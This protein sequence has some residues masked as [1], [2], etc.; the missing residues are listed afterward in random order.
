M[1]AFPSSEH[2]AECST[3]NSIQLPGST[4]PKYPSRIL[5]QHQAS[6]KD[7]VGPRQFEGHQIDHHCFSQN[8]SNETCN[9][10]EFAKS[11]FPYQAELLCYVISYLGK[12]ITSLQSEYLKKD[13][14]IK[15]N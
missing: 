9:Y 7:W 1:D 5:K 10:L 8:T 3:G 6:W 4:L 13:L 12:Q 2:L 11:S 14:L 15:G